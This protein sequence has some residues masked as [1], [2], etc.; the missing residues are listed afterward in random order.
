[1][2]T[3][4]AGEEQAEERH[5]VGVRGKPARAAVVQLAEDDTAHILAMR[6]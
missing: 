1:L 3:V 6:H 5:F 4:V 2:L